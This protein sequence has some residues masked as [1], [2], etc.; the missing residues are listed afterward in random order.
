[1]AALVRDANKVFAYRTAQESKTS[2]DIYS[3]AGKSITRINVRESS[4]SYSFAFPRSMIIVRQRQY[5]GLGVVRRR[6]TSG[7]VTGWHCA[8]LHRPVG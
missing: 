3:S 2:I 6:T 4:P 1:V 8:M 7:G 5:Q